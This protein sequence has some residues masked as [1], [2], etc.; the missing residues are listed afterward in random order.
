MTML[1]MRDA[2]SAQRGTSKSHFWQSPNARNV[3]SRG[4]ACTARYTGEVG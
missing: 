2:E 3:A 1:Q 4:G